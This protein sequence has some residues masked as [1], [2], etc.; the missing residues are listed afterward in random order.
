MK[1]KLSNLLITCLKVKR[2]RESNLLSMYET[3]GSTLKEEE[4]DSNM[5][6]RVKVLAKT[7]LPR[8]IL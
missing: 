6:Q 7:R 4:K 2:G 8:V 3:L 1:A 5:D